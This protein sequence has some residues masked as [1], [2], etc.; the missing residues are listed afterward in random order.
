MAG[1]AVARGLRVLLTVDAVG[2][3]WQ[4]GLDLARGLA[5]R[6]AEPVLVVLGPSPDAAQRAEAEAIS[7]ARLIDTGLPLDWLCEGPEPI[8]KAAKVVA[9]IAGD[10]RADIVQANMPTLAAAMPVLTPIVAVT[11]GCVSTWWAAARPGEP[12]ARQ[13]GWHRTMTGEGLRA[14][15]R[16]VAPS[17][18]YARTIAQAYDLST[19]PCV[20]H[21]G[22]SPIA[23]VSAER[24]TPRAL[25]VGRLWDHVKQ[26]DLL[27]RVAA[28]LDVPFDAA[29]A[30]TGPHGE[31]AQLGHLVQL[32]QLDGEDLGRHLARRPVFVSAASFEPFGLAVLEAAQAGCAL[33]LSDIDT[34]GE[35]WNDAALF[36]PHDK[37]AA[38]VHAIGALLRDPDWRLELGEKAR[39]RARRFTP[40]AMADGMLAIYADV[41]GHGARSSSGKVAA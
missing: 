14:A 18:S 11:H 20:V 8:A 2:G 10:I 16:V 21:N 9:G 22:R 29:G 40:Q 17:A 30:V 36:V 35:L 39:A 3:V 12:L 7:G 34:F 1:S 38:Y 32:G 28:R 26:A 5:A 4:Y 13:F 25:T 37:D 15:D 41:L 31:R 6:G 27:D 24:L 23:T 19:K 33:V